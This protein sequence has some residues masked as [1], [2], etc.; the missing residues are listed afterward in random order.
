M[1]DCLLSVLS[2]S[3]P[4]AFARSFGAISWFGPSPTQDCATWPCPLSC[5]S[6]MMFAS[7]PLSTPPAAAPPSRPPNPPGTRSLRLPPGVA[8]VP[9]GTL[10][11]LPPNNPPR[12][13]PSPPPGVPAVTVPPGGPAA[14]PISKADVEA[15]LAKLA[16]EQ[17]EDFEWKTSIVDLMKLLKLDSSLGARKQLAQELGY[18]GAEA[19]VQFQ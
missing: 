15:I 5:S 4:S 7:P 17:D 3:L 14:K 8:P 10:P 18:T 11:G 19:V 12:M 6:F 9:A 16:E 2:V 1:P 13:S